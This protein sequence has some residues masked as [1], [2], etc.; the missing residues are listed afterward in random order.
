MTRY[1]RLMYEVIMKGHN[2]KVLLI[3]A[4]PV[5]N[6]LTDLKNQLSI[7]TADK[8]HAFEEY[9]IASVSNLL[10]KA[11]KEINEWIDTEERA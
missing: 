10:R 9:G 7:I 8:D 1:Q 3:S 6:S 4:T 11:Q 5:N 2:T